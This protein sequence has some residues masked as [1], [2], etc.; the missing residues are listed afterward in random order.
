MHTVVAASVRGKRL[1]AAERP[2]EDA[3][4]VRRIGGAVIVAV[5]DGVGS[6]PR[7]AAGS[8][9][10]V[11]AACGAA[12]AW[13]GGRLSP[14]ELPALVWKRWQ[15]LLTGRPE[16]AAS[17]V[18]LVAVRA[19]SAW[20]AASLGDTVFR[21]CPEGRG[22]SSRARP[23]FADTTTALGR[24]H[25]A[26]DWDVAFGPMFDVGDV[27]LVATDGVA[28]DIDL[29]RIDEIGA[30]IREVVAQGGEAAAASLL[31]AQ[32]REWPTV[33]NLDDKTLAVV[34]GGS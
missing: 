1:E 16:D 24:E 5:A 19:D 17:T 23:S 28:E 6:K 10:A 13:F 21:V 25:R 34:L 12:D 18:A 15:Q 14:A 11:E 30:R 8:R 29:E 20:V 27:A 4:L 7:A 26:E 33:G 31:E 3:L 22:A 2:N 32:L 9:A